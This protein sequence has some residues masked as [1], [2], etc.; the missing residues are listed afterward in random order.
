MDLK[1][2]H[3]KS[4]DY[5]METK[6]LKVVFRNGETYHYD[7]VPHGTWE[8]FM[9]AESPGSFFR[10]HIRDHFTVNKE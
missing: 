5:D 2:S 7:H 9:K 8:G 1:S 10:I 3:L 4:A 6:R